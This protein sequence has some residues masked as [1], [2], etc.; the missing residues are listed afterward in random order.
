MSQ[1]PSE[2]RRALG[3]VRS[4]GAIT[5]AGV[6]SESGVRTYRGKGGI[7]DD[8]VEGERT[9]EAL[10]GPTFRRDPERTWRVI[11]DLLAQAWN[12]RPNPGHLALARIEAHVERFSLLTQNVDG[13]HA[14]AGSKNVIDIHGDVR[15]LRC[16][17][18]GRRRTVTSPDDVA[19]PPTCSC[20]APLRPDVVLFGEML[21]VDRVARLRRDFY[22]EVPD[23]VIL[24]GT[25]ALFPYVAEPVLLARAM[26]KLTVEV[27]PEPT[28]LSDAVD[29]SLRG[30]G[31]ALLPA[32]A[33][34][35]GA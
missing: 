30:T 15:R 31:G 2:L 6:S 11:R 10:S 8:P 1:L 21:P 13:L 17:S 29:Y 3:G 28:E 5:G 34:A 9:V 22:E 20:G 33:E 7:Y 12:A 27:N 19:V 23:L 16:D 26:G 14:A 32:L 24:A 18:C 35:L 25:S 4:V